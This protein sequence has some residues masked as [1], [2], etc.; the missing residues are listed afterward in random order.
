M[1]DY[2]FMPVDVAVLL[3]DTTTL[4]T[5]EFG[6]YNLLID[7]MW[8][9]KGRLP[10][11]DQ[12]LARICR[13]SVPGWQSMRVKLAR[14][15]I[16]EEGAVTQKR[17]LKTLEKVS[18]KFYK[19]RSSNERFLQNKFS[20]HSNKNKGLAPPQSADARARIKTIIKKEKE[21]E[22]ESTGNDSA[23]A[24]ASPGIEGGSPEPLANGVDPPAAN[25]ID[26]L[27]SNW[28]KPSADLFAKLK[29]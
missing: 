19:K 25:P 9:H 28:P 18:Q 7:H 12:E 8:L 11:D 29:H 14:F 23:A 15:L 5:R 13:M 3:A 2:P 4:T 16:F 21:K 17:V 1:T 22:K 10:D 27:K 20:S 24:P 6:A 26:R